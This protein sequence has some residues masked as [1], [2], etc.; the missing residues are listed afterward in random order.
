PALGVIRVADILRGVGTGT[1]QG[2]YA[3]V[4]C[5]MPFYTLGN[6][7]ATDRW[8][9][10]VEYPVSKAPAP[11]TAVTL[12]NRSGLFFRVTK[13]NSDL[14]IPLTLDPNTR[15]HTMGIDFDVTVADPPDFVVF[16]N[17]IGMFRFGGRR[18]GK[19]LFFGSFE[20]FDKSKYVIDLGTPFIETTL[21]RNFALV[22]GHTYHFSI[23][24]DNDQQSI[25]YLITEH[26]GTVMDVL[27]G[28]YNDF[29][30]VQG[31]A[32]IIE[33]GLNGVADNAYFP[34]YGWRFS[35]LKIV[36]TK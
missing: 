11:T 20:N 23:A 28:L 14:K 32:P 15:Y 9:S 31:N 19:T 36:A 16:R 1:A 17:V 29:N 18:F 30:V 4:S 26:G 24:L 21:K 12:D 34:P 33:I 6:Y 3:S 22:G 7:P 2:V 35:N 5:D 8:Q 10:R 27:G 13:S 25:H